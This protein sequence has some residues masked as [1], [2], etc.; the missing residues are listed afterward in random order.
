M[1][2]VPDALA[3]AITDEALTAWSRMSFKEREL[4][5]VG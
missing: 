1:Y 3:F 4:D 2:A 5:A